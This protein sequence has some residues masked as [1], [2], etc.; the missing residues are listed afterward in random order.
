MINRKIKTKLVGKDELFKVIALGEATQKPILL[1]GEPG[2]GKTQ[3]L[4]DY[5]AAMYNYDKKQARD[6]CFVIE[7]DEGTKNSEIKGR[8]NMENL[9]T[10]KKY[11]IDA[12]IADAEYVLINEVDKG[13]S[14]VRNTMLSVMREK[15]LFLGSEIRQCKWKLFAGSCN[16]IPQD[17]EENPFW[18]RFLIQYEVQRVKASDFYT[19]IWTGKGKA[20]IDVNVPEKADIDACSIDLKMMTEFVK[21]VY[22]EVS[23]RTAVELPLLAK[24]VKLIWGLGDAEAIMKTCELVCPQKANDLSN[25]LEDPAIV[26]IKTK[27]KNLASIEENDLLVQNISSIENDISQL[28]SNPSLKGQAESLKTVLKDTIQKSPNCQKM[29]EDLQKRAAAFKVA[30]N[31]GNN[32]GLNSTDGQEVLDMTNTQQEVL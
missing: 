1:V 29:M 19:K 13:S 21:V 10:E 20:E 22:K 28:A 6:K 11:T 3:T 30:Q 4:I 8:V 14:A 27:I 25:K 24:A 32:P 16:I 12:P 5:A 26:A 23:D 7:L 2:V 17:E 18:D 15:A 9:L 31:H